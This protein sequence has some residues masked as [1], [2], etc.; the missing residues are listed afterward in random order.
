MTNLESLK[1]SLNNLEIDYFLL[2]NSDEFN[3]EYLPEYAQRLQFLTGF[4]G[5][6]AFVIICQGKSAFFTDGRYTLQAD[7]QVNKDDFDIFDMSEKS[8][9][10]WLLENCEKGKIGFD[11]KIHTIN[12]IHNFQKYFGENMVAVK[13]NP[14]D[15]I[16]KNQPEAP[17]TKVFDHEIQYSGESSESK[18]AKIIKDL[19]ESEAVLLTHPAS[20]CWLLNIRASDVECTPLH[21]TFALVFKDGSVEL[22][23]NQFPEIP[24]T[25]KIIQTDFKNSNFWLYQELSKKGIE[26]K[27]KID[28][29]LILKAV[30]NETEIENAIKVHEIDGLALTK[31]L[32]WL[33]NSTDIDE[34]TASQ[35]L[36]EFRIQNKE[37]LYPSFPTI[38]GFGSNGA[39]IHYQ[40]DENTNKKFDSNSLFLV[41][42]G[43]QY[44]GGTTDVTRTVSIGTPTSEMIQNFTRVLKGHITLARVKFPK[45]TSGG[46]L[47]VLA[48]FH[49]WQAKKDYAHGTGHGVGSFSGVHE[50]PPSISKRSDG[51][52][53]QA[54]MI[55]SNEPGYYENGE[56]GIRIESLMRVVDLG[57]GFL[58]FK[59]LTLAPIDPSLI[60]FRMMTYPEKKWLAKYH[61][62]ILEKVGSEFK[63]EEKNWFKDLLEKYQ[64][65]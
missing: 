4:S 61:E 26:V 47:D 29:C 36:L 2:P 7:S 50:A 9:F 43:G 41:D 21:L 48:R 37:F 60:D 20:I 23:K 13:E 14:I 28:P 59:I 62:E 1:K 34:L 32:C 57:D 11:Q 8:P 46:D 55:L 25:I 58:G 64:T 45:G 27:N 65:I 56:Y 18:I 35:K 63:E 40:A 31:F 17:K 49:L 22:F 24:T 12:Q 5:S 42:S 3:S 38:A 39:V 19:K 33:D 52:S 16:W 6:N 15:A 51:I 44:L 54:G 53:L 30:K 10:S